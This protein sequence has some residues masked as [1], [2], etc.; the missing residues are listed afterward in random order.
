MISF[1]PKMISHP[2]FTSG[3]SRS[4]LS[5]LSLKRRRVSPWNRSLHSFAV[6]RYVLVATLISPSLAWA[7]DSEAVEQSQTIASDDE[8]QVSDKAR[9]L[10]NAGVDF[11]QDP[12]GARYDEA[13]R[14][15]SAAYAESPSWLI[16]GNLGISAMKIERDGEA[17][18]ALETYL[19]KGR[20]EL[21]QDEIIQV[22]RDL[23][24]LRASVTWV[25]IDVNV[26]DIEIQD[27]RK[28]LS[29]DSIRNLYRSADKSLRI[30]VHNGSHTMTISKPG[31]ERQ[32]WNF[33]ASGGEL[34]HAFELQP[35]SVETTEVVTT[36][37]KDASTKTVRP[38]PTLTWVTLGTTAACAIGAAVTGSLALNKHSKYEETN[39]GS[40]VQNA[41]DLRSSGQTLNIVTDVL[42]GAAVVSA[43]VA[44]VSYF[45][46]PRVSVEESAFRLAPAPLR[47]GGTLVLS[48]DF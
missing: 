4:T 35:E 13:Y 27:V 38:V 37:P 30:G 7:D 33:T 46:R 47:R 3:M 21:E 29:G 18:E 15:F 40:D 48:G 23:R 2:F 36:E 41:Q 39:D 25:Q 9:M 11:L 5:V 32:T 24:T 6:M 20:A 45:T 16:L 28:P 42:I 26:A 12:D 10:F 19:R 43:G 31:Y 1:R 14:S 34:S 8:V 17:L 22:E 44:A